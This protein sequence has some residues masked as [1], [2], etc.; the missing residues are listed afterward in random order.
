MERY[1]KRFALI[2]LIL[3]AT[4]PMMASDCQDTEAQKDTTGKVHQKRIAVQ[5]DQDGDTVEQ[6]NIAR[7]IVADNEPGSIKHLY[8]ISPFTGDVLFY[9]SVKGKV[10]SGGKRLKPKMAAAYY[11]TG[12]GSTSTYTQEVMNDDGTFGSSSEYIYWWDAYG[13]YHQEMPGGAI[14]HVASR[15][16]R[17]KK[18]VINIAPVQ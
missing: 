12:D 15:P 14:V 11:N 17:V 9:S 6:K 16:L 13:T 18:A 2:C 7:R 4:I 3:C 10:T 1:W 5:T 8:L